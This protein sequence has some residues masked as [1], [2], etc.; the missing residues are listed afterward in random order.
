MGLPK[1]SHHYTVA[2]YLELEETAEYKSQYFEGEIFAMS[3]GSGNHSRLA[4]DCSR[5]MSSVLIDRGCEVFNSDLKIRIQDSSAY[6]YPDLSVVC[7]EADFEDE[8]ESIL[9]NPMLIVEVLSESTESFD[10]GKKFHRYRQISSFVEYVLISQTEV[11]V[12]VFQKATDGT[13]NM[14]N[15]SGIEDVM[16]LNSLGIQIK[17]ADIYR[18]VRFE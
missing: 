8:A 2:E 11:Q 14:R 18:R 12:D 1:I 6:Y 5:A 15:Y 10:R 3:G 9:K 4:V 7:G 17:L 16:E 13:W